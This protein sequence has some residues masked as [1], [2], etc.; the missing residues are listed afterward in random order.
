M[1]SQ[2]IDYGNPRS[3]GSRLR[4]RRFRHFQA[5]VASAR[6]RKRPVNILDIGGTRDYW[7]IVPELELES[8]GLAITILNLPGDA[9]GTDDAIFRY[10]VGDGCDLTAFSDGEF[11]VVHSNSVIEHV[12][13]WTRMMAF[14]K[15]VRRLAPSY[16]VQTPNFWF[17]IEPHYMRPFLHW[18]PEPTRARLLA[19]TSI[20]QYPRARSMD[21]A[22]RLVQ[23]NRLLS[24]ATLASL[25]PD[26]RIVTERLA[27][28][29]KSL[30][31]IR[32][33]E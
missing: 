13:D 23:G 21:E 8:A 9:A 28:L 11:D 19:T 1:I 18:I 20:G 17:P 33:A 10:A 29:P 26:A 14:A 25:F 30:M 24:R 32:A 5:L 16:Y 7:R 6:N 4:A 2:A 15:E 27:L 3:I 12:G 31:A 22:M